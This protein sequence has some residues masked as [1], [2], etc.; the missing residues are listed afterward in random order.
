MAPEEQLVKTALHSRHLDCGARMGAEGSWAMPLAY[1]GATDEVREVRRRAGVADVSNRG[2]LR[3]RGDGALALLERVCASDVARQED[4][5]VQPVLLCNERGGIA[6]Y[7]H[8][9]RL[10]D[11]WLLITDAMNR[12]KVLERLQAHAA[13][14]EVKI[15][16]Q[17][18]KAA[19]LAVLGPEAPRILDA[20]LPLKVS[21]LP[22]GAVRTGSLM[23]AR[24]IGM[25]IDCGGL[26]GLEVILPGMFAPLAWDFITKKA[27]DNAVAPFGAVA[28]DI[29]RIEEGLLRYGYELNETIDPFTAGLAGAVD[30]GGA[31][32][33]PAHDFLGKGALLP[34][35]QRPAAR[36]R[37][38]LVLAAPA[39]QS[40]SAQAATPDHAGA[41]ES[42]PASAGGQLILRPGAP[43][44]DEG[45]A[46]VGTIT[47]AAYSPT[48]DALIAMAYVTAGAAQA[49]TPLRIG[50][51]GQGAAA[52][53]A[54]LPFVAG[55]GCR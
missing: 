4:D 19:H 25:R 12:F 31:G 26:W 15:D 37:V 10:E 9:V 30:F 54:D 2:R 40:V 35:R 14:R 52:H 11:A 24:Y 6:E 16:D 43:I 27:G 51:A 46:E 50:S 5:T 21:D 34:M 36:K 13:G 45:G 3:I 49:G 18:E 39:G 48:M 7:A 33:G 53:V 17:T 1:R 29:L 20:V 44:F 22:R 55:A 38:G 42:K 32:A 8:M 23:I 47:S 28:R 41:E